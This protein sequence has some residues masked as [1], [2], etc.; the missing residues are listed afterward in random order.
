MKR[1]L[2]LALGSLTV[3]TPG[4]VLAARSSERCDIIVIGAGGAGLSAAIVAADAGAR[5]VVL[6]KMPIIGGNT[7][8][9][10]G[11]MNAAGTPVQL[12]KG[13]KDDWKAMY[14]DTMKGGTNRNQTEL[15]EIMTKGSAEAVTWFT[16]LGA[17]LPG[18]VRS[19][20]ARVDRTL[21]PV[22]GPSF[23]P[24][25]TRVLYDNALKRA[26]SVRKSSRAME[27]L[28]TPAGAVRGARVQDRRGDLY[29]LRASAVIIASGG[30]GSS[31]E[32][33]ARYRPEFA[34]FSTTGQPVTS[35]MRSISCRTSAARF[36]TSIRSRFIRRRRS[37]QRR[38]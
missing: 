38:W 11:G 34:G 9:A 35:A 37:A 4:S 27:I 8:L 28:T 26:V 22:G 7:A 3:L 29:E 5:V 16:S 23:G 18:L 10:A 14:E 13:I 6:E 36:S 12:A 25:I 1:R 30:Y 2:F 21:Q 20:G 24:Y 19:G 17:D 33:V 31:P 15:V 32:R